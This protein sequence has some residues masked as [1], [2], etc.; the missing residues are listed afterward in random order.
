MESTQ[1]INELIDMFEKACEKS[2]ETNKKEGFTGIVLN[3]EITFSYHESIGLM[4][5][6]GKIWYTDEKRIDRIP[7]IKFPN[8]R[9][10]LIQLVDNSYIDIK[11][12]ERMVFKL[13]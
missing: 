6:Y 2:S 13:S 9:E 8:M 10:K 11:E 12:I 5:V 7:D 3:N 4:M 1:K